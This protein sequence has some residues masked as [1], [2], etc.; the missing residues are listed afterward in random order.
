MGA[1]G[2]GLGY[3]VS[4]AGL[5]DWTEVHRMFTFGVPTGGPTAADLRLVVAFGGAVAIAVAGFLLLARRDEIPV[6]AIRSG[7]IPGALLFGAGWAIAGACPAAALVQ[8]GE[9]KAEAVVTLGGIVAGAWLHD[10]LRKR[11]GWARHSCI[12]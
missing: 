7:T 3:V 5:A 1:F 2:L 8:I 4:S 10:R 12:D 6:K 11:F 9:G